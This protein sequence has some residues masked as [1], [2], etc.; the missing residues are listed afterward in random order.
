M[1]LTLIGIMF[2]AN[3][4]TDCS[5]PVHTLVVVLQTHLVTPHATGW[6]QLFHATDPTM[7]CR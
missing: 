7:V 5:V 1:Y 6:E 2:I 3:N 4:I